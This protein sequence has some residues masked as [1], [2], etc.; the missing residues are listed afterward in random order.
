MSG[1]IAYGVER[2]LD[3]SLGKSA[4]EWFFLIEGVL[5][6]AWGILVVSFMPK[7]PETVAKRGSIIF[8]DPREHQLILQRTFLA[9]NT[10]DAKPRMFQVWW[11]LKDIKTWLFALTVAAPCLDV[12]AFGAFLPTFIKEFGFPACKCLVL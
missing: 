9:R 12:A 5:T 4:W 7:L 11:A 1:L 6:I 3:G 10:P 8:R 2:N